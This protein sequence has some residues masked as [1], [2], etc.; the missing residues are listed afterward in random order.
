MHMT[1]FVDDDFARFGGKSY[2]INKINSV[3]VRE[4]KPYSRRPAILGALCA[5]LMAL[6][7][8]GSISAP[9]GPFPIMLG[10]AAVLGWLAW[11][12]FKKAKIREHLLFLMTSSSETQAYIA[13]DQVE[14]DSLREQIERAMLGHSRRGSNRDGQRRD[15]LGRPAVTAG[16]RQVHRGAHFD[17]FPEVDLPSAGGSAACPAKRPRSGEFCAIGLSSAPLNG[18]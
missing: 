4:R 8:L 11:R 6:A 2:A 12:G 9:G 14:V 7:F 3:E 16:P 10:I 1:V 18:S 13:R 15:R 5:V 17:T